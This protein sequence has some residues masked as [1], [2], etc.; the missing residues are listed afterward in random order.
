MH[1]LF[2]LSN[3]HVSLSVFEIGGSRNSIVCHK[4]LSP[5][6]GHLISTD[7]KEYMKGKRTPDFSEG[8]QKLTKVAGTAGNRH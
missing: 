2:I 8:Q 7:F 4:G 1:T 5:H 3:K 6:F